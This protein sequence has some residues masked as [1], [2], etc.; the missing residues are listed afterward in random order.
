MRASTLRSLVVVTSLVAG[1][2]LGPESASAHQGEQGC[3]AVDPAWSP[4]GTWIV[5]ASNC[6]GNRDLYRVRPDG[7]ALTRLSDTPGAKHTPRWSP[8]SRHLALAHRPEGEDAEIQVLEM[9]SGRLR[10]VTDNGSSEWNPTW[11]P[12][13]RRLA[14]ESERDGNADIYELDLESGLETRLTRSPSRDV[15]PAW[16]PDGSVI[17]FQSNRGGAYA[18]YAIDTQGLHSSPRLMTPMEGQAVAPAWSPDGRLLGFACVLEGE[19]DTELCV[20]RPDGGDLRVVTRNDRNDF[21]PSFAP[22]GRRVVF[23]AA[24]P[25]AAWRLQV[26]SLDDGTETMLPLPAETATAAPAVPR[27]DPPN[28][29]ILV[30]DGV[31]VIDHAIPFEVFGQ[32]SLNNVFTVAKDS[33]ALT[34][35]M[36]MRILPNYTFADHP[37]PDVLVIPGGDARRAREDPVI[38]DWIRRNGVVAEYVLSTC[39]GS[40]FLADAGLLDGRRATTW[41]ARVAELARAAPGI[42]VLPSELVVHDGKVVTSNGTGL[43]AA[44][45]VLALLHGDAWANLVRLNMEYEPMPASLRMPRVELADLELPNGLYAHF[46]WRDAELLLYDGDREDWTMHWRFASESSVD[47]LSTHFRQAL[48]EDDGWRIADEHRTQDGWSATWRHGDADRAEWHDTT[49]LTRGAGGLYELV[50][51]VERRP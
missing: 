7:S 47:S 19:R 38:R 50:V 32:Y 46:P 21:A 39:V 24:E 42:Q 33:T 31:Q 40:F 12:D 23:M 6:A 41:Y 22:D 18:I 9:E 37:T 27:H 51:R 5:F 16:S 17:A 15:A 28:V 30:Y 10:T 8:D 11:S 34:T 29:A 44:L 13:G 3:E 25:E 1:L 43:E 35:Y 26:L 48:T 45:Y 49:E 14:Y 2:V 36:G 20:A 4:D